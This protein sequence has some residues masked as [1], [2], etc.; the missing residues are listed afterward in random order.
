V[1]LYTNYISFWNKFWFILELIAWIKMT[2]LS[3]GFA[4]K[5]KFFLFL[6]TA[7]NG[8]ISF[9]RGLDDV[10]KLCAVP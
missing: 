2:V 4:L 7:I 3:G 8:F 1:N 5:F 9:G 6:A 10:L